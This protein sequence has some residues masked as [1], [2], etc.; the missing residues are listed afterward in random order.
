MTPEC[1]C[2]RSMPM[3]EPPYPPCSQGTIWRLCW[4]EAAAPNGAMSARRSFEGS[5]VKRLLTSPFLC[6]VRRFDD[7][8]LDLNGVRVFRMNARSLATLEP[9]SWSIDAV[10]DAVA[11]ARRAANGFWLEC[12]VE[13]SRGGVTRIR[14]AHDGLRL[15]ATESSPEHPNAGSLDVA[16]E[17]D[18]A[19]VVPPPGPEGIVRRSP[20]ARKSSL[21]A[22]FPAPST[23]NISVGIRATRRSS[24]RIWRSMPHRFGRIPNSSGT[25]LGLSLM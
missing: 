6:R 23:R 1:L 10:R 22:R 5:T 25:S 8:G 7:R 21:S 15:R 14:F 12:D 2:D 4:S 11:A 16:I 17:A 18:L 24:H 19:V 9:S 20:L 13:S 3:G